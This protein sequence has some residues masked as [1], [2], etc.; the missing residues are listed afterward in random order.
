M[1]RVAKD[2]QEEIEA[3][4]EISFTVSDV[5]SLISSEREPEHTAQPGDDRSSPS[6]TET[7]LTD[8]A[9]ATMENWLDE[10]YL[11]T[12]SDKVIIAYLD[13]ILLLLIAVRG[14]ACGKELLQDLRHLFGT[15]LSPGTV[16]PHLIDLA[17]EDLLD[18]TELA[19]RKVYRISDTEAVFN[20]VTPT[21]N[22]LVTF[23]VVLKALLIDCEA[24]HSQSQG[25]ATNER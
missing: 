24:H 13:E 1:N 21:V 10:D 3:D 23:S 5:E 19:K 17:D 12:I 15:D 4:I 11:H 7:R 8:D 6:Y 22:R 14:E 16:Y 25:R 18:A 2:V 20:T 9:V